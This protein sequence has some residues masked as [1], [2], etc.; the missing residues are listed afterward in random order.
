MKT[1]K[2]LFLTLAIAIVSGIMTSCS[3][4]ESSDEPEQPT[5]K[6]V[7]TS[8][9]GG[10]PSSHFYGVIF[11]DAQYDKEG[12]IISY[13]DWDGKNVT[14]T[15]TSK[16]ITRK[17]SN[18]EIILSLN[19]KGLITTNS[20]YESLNFQYDSNNYLINDGTQSFQWE[21]GNM[22]K[23]YDGYGYDSYTYTNYPNT[24]SCF[25]NELE[26]PLYFNYCDPFLMASGFYGI[27]PKNLVDKE[28]D[29]GELRGSF[30]YEFNSYGYPIKILIIGDPYIEEYFLEWETL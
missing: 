24:I 13:K 15:Y 29:D 7:L 30:S 28:Y 2:F 5:V 23:E 17:D 21:N 22:V 14:Y 6:M 20:Y 8:L 12:K 1:A 18:G 9:K 16:S 11:E 4:D 3:K 19:S 25:L 27:I 10:Y 26:S